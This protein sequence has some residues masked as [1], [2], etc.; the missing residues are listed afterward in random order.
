MQVSFSSLLISYWSCKFSKTPCCAHN[1]LIYVN[2]YSIVL[3]NL[4]FFFILGMVFTVY[5]LIEMKKAADLK[6]NISGNMN[7]TNLMFI[8]ISKNITHRKKKLSEYEQLSDEET[9][10]PKS[11]KSRKSLQSLSSKS[12]SEENKTNN[13]Y[14]ILD[15]FPEENVS[16]FFTVVLRGNDNTDITMVATDPIELDS[17]SPYCTMQLKDGNCITGTVDGELVVWNSATQ[18]TVTTFYDTSVTGGSRPVSGLDSTRLSVRR[19][20]NSP[21]TVLATNT[22]SSLLLSGDAS[23]VV[24]VWDMSRKLLQTLI[25]STAQV[26]VMFLQFFFLSLFDRNN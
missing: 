11:S 4:E 6:C 25:D 12:S 26:C 16:F 3:L 13:L 17:V 23:G 20:H 14:A 10:P 18:R 1:N 2:T 9:I 15:Y 22:D 8:G 21:V 24:K 7:S 19:A 5:D